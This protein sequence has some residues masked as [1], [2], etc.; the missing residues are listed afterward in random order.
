M[1]HA[2]AEQISSINFKY[3]ERPF[4]DMLDKIIWVSDDPQKKI[5]LRIQQPVTATQLS[6]QMGLSSSQC[7]YVLER[8]SKHGL[9]RCINPSARRS[10]LYWLT[11]LGKA[12]QRRLRHL[13]RLRPITHDCPDF[14]WQLYGEI[15]FNHRA[16]VVRVLSESMQPAQIKRKALFRNSKIRISAN[17]VRDVIRFLQAKG[18]VEPVV[19]RKR[20]HPLYRLTDVGKQMQRLLLQAEVAP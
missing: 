7:S 9:A 12:W 4:P 19:F 10:R 2:G 1:L 5:F 17:N 16:A 20:V 3:P 13:D 14:D 6:R 18:I 15:C 8:L 11:R